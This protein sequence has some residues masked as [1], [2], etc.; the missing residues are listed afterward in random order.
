MNWPEYEA[1]L[2][3]RGS[4]T[5]WLTPEALASW[6]APKRKTRGGQH[7][8]SD[9]AIETVL[10]LGLAFDVSQVEPL[11]D[12]ID[13]PI[14]Q[15]T[16]DGAYDGAPSTKLLPITALMLPLSFRRAPTRSNGRREAFRPQ[17]SAYRSNQQRRL[18]EMA[19]LHRLRQARAGRDRHRAIQV[20]RRTAP[21]GSVVPSPADGSCHRLRRS[22]LNACRRA[23]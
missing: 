6:Q 19:G 5:L 10:T 18:D 1:W 13:R 2:C 8:Y 22:Q 12:Q 23:P 7:R 9:L 3:R 11:L 21:S 15:F 20:P 17:G 14:G 16:A 4:L